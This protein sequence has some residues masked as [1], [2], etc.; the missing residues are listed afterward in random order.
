MDVLVVGGRDGGFESCRRAFTS[1]GGTEAEAGPER[2]FL[3][4]VS[5]DPVEYARD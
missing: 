3:V 1:T 5:R 2:A 4:L